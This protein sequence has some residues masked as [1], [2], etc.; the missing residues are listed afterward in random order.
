MFCSFGAG[1]ILLPLTVNNAA[2]FFTF[3]KHSVIAD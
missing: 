2:F 1:L 3:E